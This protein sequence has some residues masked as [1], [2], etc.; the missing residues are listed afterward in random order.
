MRHVQ[1]LNIRY[2][3]SSFL[4]PITKSPLRTNAFF[5]VLK[6]IK[7]IR[8]VQIANVIHFISS[9]D[10]LFTF[11]CLYLTVIWCVFTQKCH[12]RNTQIMECQQIKSGTTFAGQ[13]HDDILFIILIRYL[14]RGKEKKTFQTEKFIAPQGSP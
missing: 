13:Y 6:W 11:N 14:L 10:D 1:V 3:N 4:E 8:K 2:R 12:Y 7:Q 9:N 5:M